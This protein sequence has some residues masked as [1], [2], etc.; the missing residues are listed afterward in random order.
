MSMRTYLSSPNNQLQAHM[1]S[2]MDVLISFAIYGKW[3]ADYT[4]AYDHILID[5]G[6]YSALNSD[7]SIDVIE[8]RDWNQ[9]W[10]DRAD[11]IAGLDDISG[12]WKLSLRNYEAGGGFP[13]YH[14]T[15]PPELLADL[16]ELAKSRNNWLGVGVKPPR[17]NRQMWLQETLEQ[18]PEGIHVHGWALR[19]YANM[20]R[21]DSMDS[22]NWF[23]TALTYKAMIPHLTYAE[24]LEI[25]V[26]RYQRESFMKPEN[27]VES[28]FDSIGRNSIAPHYENEG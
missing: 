7:E 14:D 4:K 3:M 18:I 22:T 23:R 5:S 8:Y 20:I 27:P 25:S 10:R 19:R 13:T 1:A 21:F 15:D 11:A 28:L 24:C 6:A 17:H 9:Q 16:I 12:N 26:K 2:G